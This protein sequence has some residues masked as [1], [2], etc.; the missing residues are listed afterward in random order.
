MMLPCLNDQST[1]GMLATSCQPA[2]SPSVLQMWMLFALNEA[3]FSLSRPSA[4]PLV[5]Q[6]RMLMQAL[7]GGGQ[8]RLNPPEGVR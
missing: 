5:S 2:S 4:W 7:M 6:G 1:R 3:A 8:L